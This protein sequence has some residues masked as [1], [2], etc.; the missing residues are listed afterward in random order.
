MI[1]YLIWD[2]L[3][4]VNKF[5]TKIVRFIRFCSLMLI[6]LYEKTHRMDIIKYVRK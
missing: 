1:K 2:I 3:V 4:Y 6:L 5:I